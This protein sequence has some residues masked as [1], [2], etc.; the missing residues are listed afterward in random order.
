MSAEGFLYFTIFCII[1]VGVGGF[2]VGYYIGRTSDANNNTRVNIP[3]G[4]Y[5]PMNS[6]GSRRVPDNLTSVI[7]STQSVSNKVKEIENNE[8][9]KNK[10]KEEKDFIL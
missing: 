9:S 4:G 5:Q 6:P 3:G 10:P 7:S 1:V 2:W 8:N